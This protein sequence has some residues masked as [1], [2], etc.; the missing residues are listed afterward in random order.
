MDR[1]KE[2]EAGILAILDAAMEWSSDYKNYEELKNAFEDSVYAYLEQEFPEEA[3][4]W[5]SWA[6]VDLEATLKKQ[7]LE[8]YFD[9]GVEAIGYAIGVQ[10]IHT[11][12][13]YHLEYL[14]EF[15][16]A[17]VDEDDVKEALEKAGIQPHAWGIAANYNGWGNYWFGV[18]TRKQ[19]LEEDVDM[20][21]LTVLATQN[22]YELIYPRSGGLSP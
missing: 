1:E 19:L 20:D 15:D 13:R 7:V 4:N 10:H 3:E 18:L 12:Y 8:R 14:V 22:N 21:L 2:I 9:E 16:R 11:P 6:D 5:Q 17:D